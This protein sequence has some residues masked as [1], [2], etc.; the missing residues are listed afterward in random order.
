MLL[1][2]AN[3]GDINCEAAEASNTLLE[4]VLQL[5]VERVRVCVEQ[6]WGE[7]KTSKAANFTVNSVTAA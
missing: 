2:W 1:L 6:R 3:E 4:A 5:F 7:A